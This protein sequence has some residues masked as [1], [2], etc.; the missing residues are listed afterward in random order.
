MPAGVAPGV[1]DIAAEGDAR[2]AGDGL[3]ARGEIVGHHLAVDGGLG[4]ALDARKHQLALRVRR[5]Q[6]AHIAIV[7]RGEHHGVEAIGHA[8]FGAREGPD[9]LAR[10]SRERDPHTR[11]LH[12][13]AHARH[14]RAHIARKDLA[15][16][17][18]QDLD[19]P[20]RLLRPRLQDAHRTG[21]ILR[22]KVADQPPGAALA[23]G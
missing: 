15:I 7:N 14:K 9:E 10:S 19:R 22:E 17:I 4:E 11:R 13:L 2:A 6:E 8:R 1:D 5:P 23:L 16:P 20:P 12:H 3:E 18:A 21:N